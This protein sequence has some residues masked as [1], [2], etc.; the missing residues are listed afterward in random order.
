MARPRVRFARSPSAVGV[1][2]NPVSSLPQYPGD[3]TNEAARRSCTAS[4]SPATRLSAALNSGYGPW[5]R[6]AVTRPSAP[7][8]RRA[9]SETSSNGSNPVTGFSRRTPC[10][11]PVGAPPVPGPHSHTCAPGPVGPAGGRSRPYSRSSLAC[12]LRRDAPR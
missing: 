4:S 11:A 1:A 6:R 3:R 9:P 7:S 8:A 12:A 10:P 5:Y 2:A